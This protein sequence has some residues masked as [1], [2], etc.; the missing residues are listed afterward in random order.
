MGKKILN[1]VL[2]KLIKTEIDLFLSEFRPCLLYAQIIRIHYD[3]FSLPL[4][5]VWVLRLDMSGC[6]VVWTLWC[7]GEDCGAFIE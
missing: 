3:W 6:L 5:T 2:D 7:S 1:F 4:S